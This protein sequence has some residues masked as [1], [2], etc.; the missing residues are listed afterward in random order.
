MKIGQIVLNNDKNEL[1]P[2]AQSECRSSDPGFAPAE[3]HMIQRRSPPP[4]SFLKEP[5]RLP[6][7]ESTP[8]KSK[9][10]F[11]SFL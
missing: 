1:Y 9:L 11:T 4:P 7:S 3:L 6:A 8:G 5:S 10:H 2:S